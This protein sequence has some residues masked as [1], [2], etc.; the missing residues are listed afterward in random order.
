MKKN[1]LRKVNE[2]NPAAQGAAASRRDAAAMKN[3]NLPFDYYSEQFYA[4][5]EI[6]MWLIKRSTSTQPFRKAAILVE[7]AQNE[8]LKEGR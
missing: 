2:Y 8:M 1:I 4:L 7:K 6:R 5:E 3:K